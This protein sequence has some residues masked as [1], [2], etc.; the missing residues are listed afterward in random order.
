VQAAVPIYQRAYDGYKR[1]TGPDSSG[2]LTEQEFMAG[3]LMK[4]GRA[5]EALPL[6]EASMPTWRKLEPGS[7]DLSEPL[8]FLSRAYVETGHFGEA[9]NGA[10]EMLAVQEGKVAATDRRFGATHMIW[11]EA[12]LGQHKY[13]EALPHAQKADELLANAISPG[14]KAM[15]AEAH[16]VLVDVQAKLAP[17]RDAAPRK[18]SAALKNQ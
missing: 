5:K 17:G 12:L 16:Q 10:K 6:M 1:C 4:L 13:E 14:A 3:A 18:E 8:Y 2:A 15:S 11:A 9:E 7:P